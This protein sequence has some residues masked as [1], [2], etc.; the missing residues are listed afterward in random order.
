MTER[1]ADDDRASVSTD[2]DKIDVT[3]AL[4]SL[5]KLRDE[6]VITGEEFESKKAE[7]LRKYGSAS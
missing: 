2:P 7:W 6:G 5:A 1:R 3:E 4:K